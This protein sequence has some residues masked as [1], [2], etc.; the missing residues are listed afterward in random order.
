MSICCFICFC[1]AEKGPA[2]MQEKRSAYQQ[3]LADSLLGDMH[4]IILGA[5]LH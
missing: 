4:C 2:G 1:W 5:Q 3:L